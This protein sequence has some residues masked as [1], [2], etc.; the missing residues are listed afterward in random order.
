[1]SETRIPFKEMCARFEVTPR[2]LRYYEYIELLN[3]MR[4]GRARFYTQRDAARMTL[5]LG[6]RGWG[7][8][9]EDIRKWQLI[10]GSQGDQPRMRARVKL[11]DQQLEHLRSEWADMQAAIDELQKNRD[12]AASSLD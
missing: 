7:V 9:L 6:V 3:P 2:T 10:Y 4:D 1:M 5:I 11:A 12:E 8:T